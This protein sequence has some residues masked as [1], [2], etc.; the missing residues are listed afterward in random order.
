MFG[1]LSGV[2]FLFSDVAG[3]LSP[4]GLVVRE[5]FTGSKK[6]VPRLKPPV[7]GFRHSPGLLGGGDRRIALHCGLV[8]HHFGVP[9]TASAA[10][11]SGRRFLYG[12]CWWPA[13]SSVRAGIAYFTLTAAPHRRPA[14]LLRP[15]LPRPY[16]G[17]LMTAGVV[18][19]VMFVDL[20]ES[21]MPSLLHAS[22]VSRD[23][24]SK[25]GAHGGGH[26]IVMHAGTWRGGHRLAGGHAGAVLQIRRA[27]AAVRLGQP[28]TTL[29][30]YDNV[31]SH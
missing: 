5:A 1:R 16:A 23:R 28:Q 26:C 31:F 10:C 12:A 13:G 8:C 14:D 3:A 27:R 20:R 30:V 24:R 25:T 15:R 7:S 29:T 11:L 17:L 6:P 19:K 2:F 21:L 4:A 22:K 9:L 18:Q